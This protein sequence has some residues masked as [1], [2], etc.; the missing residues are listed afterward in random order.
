MTTGD[1]PLSLAAGADGCAA[2]SLPESPTTG[3]RWRLEDPLQSRHVTGAA[4][5][6]ESTRALAGGGGTRVFTVSLLGLD[7]VELAFVLCGPRGTGVIGRQVVT[8][9][10]RR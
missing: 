1:A 8:V 2:V 4:F 6:P 5:V 7:A 10:R 9:S 3:N